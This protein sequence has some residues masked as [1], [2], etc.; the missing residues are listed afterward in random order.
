MLHYISKHAQKKLIQHCIDQL[1]L[2]GTIIIRDGDSDLKKR[3]EGTR[4]TETFST[5]IFG[6][7]KINA[8]GLSYLSGKDIENIA[9]VNN[10]TVERIDL[11]QKT[12]NII[13]IMRK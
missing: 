10:L 3:H 6:F 12:S 13:Y 7:N 2:G 9:Q 4:W 5:Q 1:Q 11:T 8:E